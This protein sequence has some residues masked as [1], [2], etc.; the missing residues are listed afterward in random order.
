MELRLRR[1]PCGMALPFRNSSLLS[2][3][4]RRP[5]KAQPLRKMVYRLA[6]SRRHSARQAAKPR[7]SRNVLPNN[8]SLG[9]KRTFS[10]LLRRRYGPASRLE[11][12][13]T[14]YTSH[15][16]WFRVV[17]HSTILQTRS[18]MFPPPRPRE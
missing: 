18:T 7:G 12:V 17:G 8:F 1:L 5:C 10:H 14:C 3:W 13:L 4:L 9:T 2:A 16:V 15:S 11:S 6:E